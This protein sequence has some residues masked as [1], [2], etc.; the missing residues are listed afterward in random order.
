MKRAFKLLSIFHFFKRSFRC[1]KLSLTLECTFKSKKNKGNYLKRNRFTR[2]LQ[3]GPTKNKKLSEQQKSWHSVDKK[4]L[5]LLVL[6]FQLFCLQFLKFRKRIY[7]NIILSR[8]CDS[9]CM[10]HMPKIWS[11]KWNIFQCYEIGN[12]SRSRS[13][14]INIFEIAYLDPKLKTWAH[15]V[16]KLQ[17]ARF[18]WTLALRTN[19]TC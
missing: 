6:E 13:L 16:S 2:N 5:S 19:R 15:L 10:L 4:L 14:I 3:Q 11:Q 7:K 9:L 8:H 1:Q 12:Q 17:Y 18:L